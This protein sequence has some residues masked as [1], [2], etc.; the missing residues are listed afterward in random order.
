MSTCRFCGSPNLLGAVYCQDCGKELRAGKAP[1]AKVAG[2]GPGAVEHWLE[3]ESGLLAGKQFQI[4]A[5]GLRV[6]RHPTQNQVVLNDDEV[7]R[8]HARLTLDAQGNVRLEDSSFN[9]TYVNG[10]RAEQ[11]VLEP[12]D[13]IR[14]ALNPAN[15]FV[16]RRHEPGVKPP[17]PRVEPPVPGRRKTE[18]VA[19]IKPIDPGK[20]VVDSEKP[21]P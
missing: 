16:Y 11:A 9:G 21:V 10:R 6:G 18:P 7:S 2:R 8:L 5:E 15:L 20:T 14:F 17:P 19:G 12:G 13:K 4:T 1:P 3:G